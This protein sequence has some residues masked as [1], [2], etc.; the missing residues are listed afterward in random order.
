MRTQ[1]NCPQ[2]GVPF[3]AE[4]HQI[5]D[6]DSDPRLKQ[7]FLSGQLNVAVCP[8]CGAGGQ[9]ATPLVFHDSEHELFMIHIPQEIHINQ[10]EREQMIGRL[11]RQVVDNLPPEKRK[12][13]LFQPQTI[14]NMQTFA[15]KVLE[16]E[17]V[18]KEMIERQRKQSELLNTLARADKDVVEY[19]LKDRQG[20]IDE[21]FFAM[22]QS[23]IDNAQ[24]AQNDKQLVK[25]TNLRAKLMRETAAGRQ[26]EKEQIAMHRFSQAAKKQGGLSPA[27]L[28]EHI[29]KNLD[30]EGTIQK[31]VMAGQSALTYDFFALL[32]AELEQQEQAG[33]QANAQRLTAV[34]AD[35]LE[36][37][38][39]L[40]AASQHMV[41]E[42]MHTL[43]ALLQA[44]D[45]Q[46]A[47][48]DNMERFDD[49]FM[50]I[51]SANIAQ[52]T[53]QGD[54]AQLQALSAIQDLIVR[55]I[56]SQYPPEVIFLNQLMEAESEVAQQEMLDNNSHLVGPNLIQMLD[57]VAKQIDG[58][59]QSDVNGR[60]QSLKS[61]IQARL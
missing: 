40:Q 16:T 17:G 42:A 20:E 48:R 3:V 4:V 56:E 31:L 60:I 18:T 27:L 12:A 15:E 52:A 21:T 34:R 8:S 50:Y 13:Y 46:A 51:L 6:V 43:R 29:V 41:D 44:P 2:C 30:N 47:I 25:L 45:K 61:V 19:L 55:E 59:G 38:S 7:M 26:L 10:L 58:M 28:L 36:V 54:E 49:A 9:L 37:Q 35:L 14:L 11:T 5:I 57:A 24:Q 22:L 53:Q 33:N 23:Y 32:T 39:Q 1:L